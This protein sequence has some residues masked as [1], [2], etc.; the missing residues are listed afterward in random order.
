MLVCFVDES[1]SQAIFSMACAISTD[2]KWLHFDKE[3]KKVLAEYRVPYFHM[4]ELVP[5]QKG[6]YA[7]WPNS[8]ADAF[9][10]KL[11]WVFTTYVTAWFGITVDVKAYYDHVATDRRRRRRNPYFHAFQSCISAVLINCETSGVKD[12]ISFMID[13]GSAS[14]THATGYFEALRQLSG[15]PNS[16]QLGVLLI[17]DDKKNHA[18]QAADFLAYEIN[19]HATGF[20]RRS[21]KALCELPHA[22]IN[23]DQ[24]SLKQIAEKLPPLPIVPSE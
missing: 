4:R 7:G 9:I 23:W 21:F 20:E 10:R 12:K 22:I 14:A 16:D 5:R 17:G 8:R 6:P 11:T 1:G 19:K 18:L 13:G 2:R 24:E 3:W 15:A